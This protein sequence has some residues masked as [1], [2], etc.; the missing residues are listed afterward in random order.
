MLGDKGIPTAE[1]TQ[2]LY[3]LEDEMSNHLLAGGN[4]VFLARIT[5]R[6]QRELAYRVRDPETADQQLERLASAP[7][8]PRPW[9]YRMEHDPK[10]N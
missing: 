5:C 10:F 7:T 3:R 8:P 9:E 1:E 2:T 6:G 4:A